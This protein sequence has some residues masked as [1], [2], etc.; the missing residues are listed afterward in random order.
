MK[1]KK[2]LS[3]HRRDFTAIF[4]CEHCGAE[5]ERSGYDDT[6]F[7]K[8]VIPSLVCDECG[9]TAPDTYVPDKPRHPDHLTI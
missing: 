8:D 3:Q 9:K 2:K 4:V 6:Y 5:I 1:I 7:H